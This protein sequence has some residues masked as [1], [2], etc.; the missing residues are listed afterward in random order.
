MFFFVLHMYNDL[1]YESN[2]YYIYVHPVLVHR[3]RLWAQA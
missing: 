3:L 2:P 1:V